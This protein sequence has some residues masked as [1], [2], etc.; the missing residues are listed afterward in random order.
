MWQRQQHRV[1]AKRLTDSFRQG[2]G[3][4]KAPSRQL[5]HQEHRSRA[6]QFQLSL[7]PARTVADGR[8][9]RWPVT[10]AGCVSA[11]EAAHHGRDVGVPA[12]VLA[13]AEAGPDHPA[14]EL[15]AG[16][17]HEGPAQAMFNR[18]RRLPDQEELRVPPPL[19]DGFRLSDE[20]LLGA[21][22][23]ARAG[24]LEIAKLVTQWSA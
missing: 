5:S 24:G 8:G 19:E 22:P 17:T 15:V 3:P 18:T 11:G 6:N 21:G 4:E 10:A 7:Q 2:R 1:G 14:L 12:E 9:G 23:A 16:A 20:T 13:G